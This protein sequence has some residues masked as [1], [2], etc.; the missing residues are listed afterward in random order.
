MFAG[1]VVWTLL[2]V[3]AQTASEPICNDTSVPREDIVRGELGNRAHDFL[4]QMTDDGFSGAVLLSR[5]GEILLKMGYGYANR[6]ELQPNNSETLF[7]VASVA[8]I[9]TAAAVLDLEEKQALSLENPLSTYLGKFPDYKSTATV[10]HLLIHTAGLVARGA[11]LEYGSRES[12]VD[13]VKKA[14]FETPPGKVFRYTNAGYTLLAAIVETVSG[15][16]FE[17]YL[18]ERLFKR[19]CMTQTAFVW[20]KRVEKLPAAVGYAGDTIDHLSAV[21]PETDIWGNRGPSNIAT[22]VGDLYRWIQAVKSEQIISNSSISKMFTAYVG[23]EGY[24]WHV[25]DTEHGR[26]LRRGGGLLDFESSLR[27]YQDED[28]VIIVLINNHLGLRVPIVQG[29]EDI[30][31]GDVTSAP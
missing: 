30:A 3:G 16:P 21:P 10:H 6:E 19:A 2:F 8:K 28:L 20:E 31:F 5:R 15:L 26:L 18:E 27:W 1:T 11:E 14:P 23:D 29:L 22:N 9:F 7:N 13:S 12:F 17:A 4:L 24:G 25:I